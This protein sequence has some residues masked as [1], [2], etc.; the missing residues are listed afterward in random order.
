[1]LD[2]N[3]FLGVASRQRRIDIVQVIQRQIGV[4]L[5]SFL[6]RGEVLEMVDPRRSSLP[7]LGDGHN[8]LDLMALAE[9]CE[10]HVDD[11]SAS[12]ADQITRRVFLHVDGGRRRR[13]LIPDER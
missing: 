13:R 1:M 9:K 6:E 12:M 3:A 2:F 4:Q 8:L 10:R 11:A 7:R 5:V